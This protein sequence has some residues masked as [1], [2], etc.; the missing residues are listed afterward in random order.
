VVGI[1]WVLMMGAGHGEVQGACG[2]EN[3]GAG[4]GN[5]QGA[6]DGE[7]MGAGVGEVM[8]R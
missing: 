1:S 3:M 2:G 8:G 4:H 6:H 5:V 7:I